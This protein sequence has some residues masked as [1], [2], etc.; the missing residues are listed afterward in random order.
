MQLRL[1]A[2]Q[3]RDKLYCK[4]THD[5]QDFNLL[6]E[7][8]QSKGIRDKSEVVVFE[9]SSKVGGRL[10]FI[11]QDIN[12]ELG[13]SL[14]YKEN[15]FIRNFT[16]S[17]N[18]TERPATGSFGLWNGK[19][20]V[21]AESPSTLKTIVNFLWRYKIS[22]ITTNAIV[23]ALKDKFLDIYPLLEKKQGFK[24]MGA[25]LDAV[26]LLGAVN[27]TLKFY[28]QFHGVDDIFIDEMA[29]AITRINYGQTA[30]IHALAG[31][32][33][34]L[35]KGDS[36]F[37]PVE[38]FST[39]LKAV[40]KTSTANVK[41]NHAVTRIVAS[42]EQ[43]KSN[44]KLTIKDMEKNSV[45][46][47]EFDIVIIATPLEFADIEIEGTKLPEK[48]LLERPFKVT[49]VT[50]ITGKLNRGYFNFTEEL[51]SCIATTDNDLSPFISVCMGNGNPENPVYKLFSKAELNEE[52]LDKLFITRQMT[53]R[54]KWNAYPVLSPTSKFP[55]FRLHDQLYYVN[56]VETALS[57]IET[58]AIGAKNIVNLIE[59]SWTAGQ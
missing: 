45:I 54:A 37:H 34:L 56:A 36:L 5:N 46:D 33:C 8:L 57:V 9:R 53:K 24:D 39:V 27:Q 6:N 2:I 10:D 19:E 26:R 25:L 22:P 40:L 50:V 4:T 49:H 48:V 59:A 3:K 7:F 16:V 15:Y 11:H 12:I 38:G 28:L 52:T 58:S 47:Q 23:N 44:Y 18:F 21:F 14:Y 13:G 17:H 55:P 31:A 32:V 30:S 35:A 41:L 51:P 43:G 29:T 20:F 42:K 1:V